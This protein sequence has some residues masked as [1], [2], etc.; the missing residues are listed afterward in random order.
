MIAALDEPSPRVQL[1]PTDLI[2][3]SSYVNMTDAVHFD[4]AFYRMAIALDL[5]FFLHGWR[6]VC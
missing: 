6:R 3:T 2:S 4:K 1:V 5:E